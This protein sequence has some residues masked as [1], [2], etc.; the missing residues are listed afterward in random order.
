MN[1]KMREI[2]A[3]IQEKTVQAKALME[4]ENKDI[5]KANAI[6]DE[7]DALQNE[8]AAEKRVYDAEKTAGAQ[9]A[10]TPVADHAQEKNVA[11]LTGEQVVAKEV[12]AIMSPTRFANDKSLQES[13][14]A[15]GGYIVPED[16]QTRINRWPEAEYS[17]LSDISEEIVSTN[18]GARTYQVTAD[19][20]AFVD[21]DENGAITKEITAP[22]FERV[23]FNIQDR[24]GFMPV[25]NDLVEDSDANISEVITAWL[26][27]ANIATANA[28]VKAIIADHKNPGESTKGAKAI[29]GGIDGIKKIVN[30]TLGQAYKGT[31]KI[32]TNDDGLQYLDTLK[33]ANG[34]YLLNP[35]PTDSAKL[36][37]RCGS[38]VVPVKIIPNA[39]LKTDVKTGNGAYTRVPFIIGDLQ[40]G[41]K[42]YNRKSM[43]LKA[44]DVATLGSFN[45]FAMNMTLIRAILRDD[46]KELDAK[47]Y[48]NGYIDT[49]VTN[50]TE[51][52][53]NPSGT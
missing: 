51:P 11:P 1:K 3:K 14:D 48:F 38:V 18:K 34:R 49:T 43:T 9:S 13:V 20:D 17:F 4:G 10:N 27:K 35:D 50:A 37:L 46:Y 24:A 7:V 42:R 52:A 29:A 5:A 23:T 2:L 28:K 22:T 47:A 53:E 26:A 40:Q 25:S 12:R 19:T 36:T 6:M 21:L 31:A 16:I 33:D 44:S 8:L 32:I 15:D 30:V 41:I 39:V 45:A